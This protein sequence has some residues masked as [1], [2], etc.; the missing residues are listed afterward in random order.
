MKE[1]SL[2][3]L[4]QLQETQHKEINLNL[5]EGEGMLVQDLGLE[6]AFKLKKHKME[7]VIAHLGQEKEGRHRLCFG[8]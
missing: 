8:V 4:P 6:L 3:P 5:S 1:L 2:S 7:T